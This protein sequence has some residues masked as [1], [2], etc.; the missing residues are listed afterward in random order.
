MLVMTA[1]SYETLDRWFKEDVPY[2]DLTTHVLG[3]GG[4]D[5]EMRMFFREEAVVCGTE[6]LGQLCA[7]QGVRV[8]ECIPS[9]QRARE[10]ETVI[11]IR[12]KAAS[13]HML[14]KVGQN[15]LEHASAIATRTNR[16]VQRARRINENVALVSTR[17]VF[18]GTK[19]LST[20]AVLCG[21]GLPHRLGLSETI[22]IFKQHRNFFPSQDELIMKIRA[23]KGQVSEKKI[24]A[25]IE[26]AEDALPLCEAGVGGVQ[27]DNMEPRVIA[28]SVKTIKDSYPHVVTIATGGVN[29][30]NVDKYAATGVDALATSAVYFGKPVDVG[31]VIRPVGE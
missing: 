15:I 13:L 2:L 20:K 4:R 6:E 5:G 9:G 8:V 17:K 24:I 10:N 3:I 31:V 14:W 16:M 22:L 25:E 18:P 12:G 26:R 29:E 1:I 21:G 19:E 28:E 7:L 23:L 11:S 30:G 27:F